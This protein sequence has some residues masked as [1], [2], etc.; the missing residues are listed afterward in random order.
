MRLSR[1]VRPVIWLAVLALFAS[2]CGGTSSEAG[3]SDDTA[4]DD[5]VDSNDDATDQPGE[6]DAAGD[7]EAD[8]REG[9]RRYARHYH[10]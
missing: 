3:A 4:A 8:D 2:A 9:S 6:D 5:A 1:S 10:P 7:P